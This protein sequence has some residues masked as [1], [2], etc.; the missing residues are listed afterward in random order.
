MFVLYIKMACV[1]CP[2][3][4]YI[5]VCVK[6]CILYSICNISHIGLKRAVHENGRDPFVCT[7][8]IKKVS[9]SCKRIV[10][11]LGR[12]YFSHSSFFLPF[13]KKTCETA[14][15][16]TKCCRFQP[17]ILNVLLLPRV[18]LCHSTTCDNKSKL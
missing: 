1:Y 2:L 16:T 17:S 11:T 4:L 7:L 13:R 12:C 6:V 15:S 18:P 5:S 8:N 14:T 10:I 9:I 3:F